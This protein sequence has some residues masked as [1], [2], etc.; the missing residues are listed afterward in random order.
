MS[1]CK[2]DLQL[3][4]PTVWQRLVKL[5]GG[6]WIYL[7]ACESAVFWVTLLKERIHWKC[8]YFLWTLNWVYTFA[9]NEHVLSIVTSQNLF[10]T[11]AFSQN[12]R[13]RQTGMRRH[14]PPYS[15]SDILTL[16]P[17]SLLTPNQSKQW[18]QRVLANQ[19]QTRVGHQLVTFLMLR[20]SS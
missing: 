5:F 6:R 8:S 19:R 3:S 15:A 12:G 14:D 4:A 1:R 18:S 13:N 7:F 10:K 2:P 17:N 11:L 9:T 20:I 16:T